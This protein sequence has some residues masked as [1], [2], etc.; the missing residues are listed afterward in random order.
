MVVPGLAQQERPQYTDAEWVRWM[1]SKIGYALRKGQAQIEGK[2][3]ATMIFKKGDALLVELGR[4]LQPRA[5]YNPRQNMN[6]ATTDA[7]AMVEL[8]VKVAQCPPASSSQ[9]GTNRSEATH[10]GTVAAA[11]AATAAE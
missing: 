7:Q 10:S 8:F 11:A 2:P 9:R 1:A 4:A 5:H 6:R 3:E